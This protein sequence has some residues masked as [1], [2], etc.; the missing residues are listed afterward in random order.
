MKKVIC[1]WS[2]GVTSAVACKIAIDLYGKG[3]CQVIFMDTKNEDDDSYRFLRDCE[4]WYGL[5]IDVISFVPNKYLSIQSVWRQYKALN[6]AQGAICS[7]SLKRDLRLAWEK[8]N[9]GQWSHQVFGFDISESKRSRSMKLNH[10][11]ACPIFPLML[12]AMSKKEC[13]EMIEAAGISIPR[14]YY[15]GFLNNNCLKTGCV[16]GGIGYWQKMRRDM[17][18]VFRAMADMEHE[19]SLAAGYPVTCLKDQSNEAKAKSDK[20]ETLVFLVKNPLF[21]ENKELADMKE[22]KVEPLVECNGFCF[23]NDLNEK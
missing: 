21:P 16:K 4:E 8:E 7:S 17:P 18:E 22:C 10:P 5:P 23:T 14:A 6:N 3:N 9:E 20:K 11:Q 15:M 19:L 12:H 1:W 2:G 13:I